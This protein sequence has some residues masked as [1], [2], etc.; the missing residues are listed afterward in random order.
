MKICQLCFQHFCHYS[1]EQCIL[2]HLLATF[3]ERVLSSRFLWQPV[4]ENVDEDSCSV[5]SH[6]KGQNKGG[7]PNTKTT[8][9]FNS[10]WV[11]HHKEW[12]L[13]CSTPQR[14]KTAVFYTTK[15]EDYSV[16]HH[17]ERRLQCSTPQRTKTTVFYTTK[18]EDYSWS[19]RW[20]GVRKPKLFY[21]NFT[22]LW[23]KSIPTIWWSVRLSC[24]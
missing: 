24:L 8:M 18:N 20:F 13:Q 19:T 4:V 22:W 14:M 6:W 2:P 3:T 23:V 16:L 15:N 5:C 21:S 17:K 12:R 9:N 10:V 7:R 1:K 11:L